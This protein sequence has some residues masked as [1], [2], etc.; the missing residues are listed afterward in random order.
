MQLSAYR[1]RGLHIHLSDSGN[2]QLYQSRDS[3]QQ[4]HMEPR[5]P[6]HSDIFD[7]VLLRKEKNG[8]NFYFPHN[9]LWSEK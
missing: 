8:L 1:M 5:I 6:I 9:L 7:I 3:P 2:L 4:L